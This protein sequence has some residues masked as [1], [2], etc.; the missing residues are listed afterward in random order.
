MRWMSR[1]ISRSRSSRFFSLTS[2]Y[3][4]ALYSANADCSA[5]ALNTSK[6]DSVNDAAHRPVGQREHAEVFARVEQRGDH[7]GFRAQ[8]RVAQRRQAGVGFAGGQ[9]ERRLVLARR[10][11]GCRRCRWSPSGPP[12][13][14][15]GCRRR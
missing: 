6:S 9:E 1:A 10:C 5:M 7:G 2:E 12:A 11:R 13:S 14:D 8:R 3:T 15:T 4:M